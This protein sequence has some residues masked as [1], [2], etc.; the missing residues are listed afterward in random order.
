MNYIVEWEGVPEINVLLVE[1]QE[2]EHNN[3]MT[4][5]RWL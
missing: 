5:D 1:E 2:L 3:Q 4:L